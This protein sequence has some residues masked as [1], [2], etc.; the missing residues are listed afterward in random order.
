MRAL[1]GAAIKTGA[2]GVFC[3]ILPAQGLGIALK[4]ADGATRA[5]EAAMTALLIRL[6]GLPPGHPAAL[7]R[8]GPIQNWAGLTT[9]AALAPALLAG[10]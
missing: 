6:A 3:A 8:L 9:G 7:N 2:E 1:P 4:I 5:A 10:P